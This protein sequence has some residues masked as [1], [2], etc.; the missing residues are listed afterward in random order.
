MLM[1]MSPSTSLHNS[2]LGAEIIQQQQHMQ[3]RGLPAAVLATRR[4]SV[5]CALRSLNFSPKPLNPLAA[6][7]PQ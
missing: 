4:P 5:S 6:A 2:R 3:A 1:M 7:N